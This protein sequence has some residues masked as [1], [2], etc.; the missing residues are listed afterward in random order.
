[1]NRWLTTLR[2]VT[3]WLTANALIVYEA[4][5]RDGEPRFPLLTLYAAMLGLPAM[6]NV[7]GRRNG[8][9]NGHG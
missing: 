9:G 7:T 8:N 6:L 2:D 3:I 1:M 4:A 5:F